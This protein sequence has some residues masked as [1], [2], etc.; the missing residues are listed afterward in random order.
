LLLLDSELVETLDDLIR[1]ATVTAVCFDCVDQA[2]C[3]TVMEKENTQV[4]LLALLRRLSSACRTR[5]GRRAST[6]WQSRTEP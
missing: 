2:G 1:L 3:S 4:N 6:G 5:I